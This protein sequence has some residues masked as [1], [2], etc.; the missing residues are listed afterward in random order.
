LQRNEE[1]PLSISLLKDD[2]SPYQSKIDESRS[3]SQ[4]KSERVMRSSA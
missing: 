3:S 1:W 4:E 2:A